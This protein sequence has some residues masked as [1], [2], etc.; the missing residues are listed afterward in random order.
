[1][2]QLDGVLILVFLPL[3]ILFCG[4]WLAAPLKDG[5]AGDRLAFAMLAG[6]VLLLAAVAAVNFQQPLSG[7]WAY[8]C[9]AVALPSLW[10]GN[11]VSLWQDLRTLLRSRP[12]GAAFATATYLALLLWPVLS[13][14]ASLFYDGTSNHDSFFWVA[15]AEHLKQHNYMVLPARSPTQPLL[16]ST[17]AIIGWTPAWGRMGA[18]GLL[19]LTSSILNIAPIK[20]YLYATACL[21][22]AWLAGAWLALKT[23]VT[24]RPGRLVAPALATLQPVF[25]FFYGNSNLPNLVGAIAG[26]ALI[27]A[28]ERALRSRAEGRSESDVYLVLTALSFHG[29]LCAYPE[30]APFVL[31]PA[32]L[33]WLRHGFTA[34]FHIAR[35][36][37]VLSAGAILL[38]VALNYATTARA[39]HGFV[40]S[41]SMARADQNWANLF[42]PLNLAEY[43]AGLIS[44]SVPAARQLGLW[45]G[46]PL[47]GLILGTAWAIAWRARDRLGLLAA[48]SGSGVLLLYTIGTGF[49]Y[50]WQKTVQFSGVF[51]AMLFPAAALHVLGALA[52]ESGR[53]Q[54]WP[55]RL[56][57][58]A[59]PAFMVFAT[60]MNFH[61]TYK[62]SERKVISADWFG[63]R[64]DSRTTLRQKP[65]LIEAGTFPMS[66]FHGMWS[67]YFLSESYIYF[68]ARGEQSGG[69]LRGE[70]A[71]EGRLDI[72]DP[73]AV[74]V[75][76]NWAEGFDS[77]SP[78]LRVGREYALLAR[79][80]RV[81]SME[82]VTP[83]N[84]TPAA[85]AR[86]FSF[87]IEPAVAAQ[88]NFILTPRRGQEG[89]AGDWEIQRRTADGTITT[90][91]VGGGPPWRISVP[92]NGRDSQTL[93]FSHAD[94]GL[95]ETGRPF[96]LS[97]LRME[98]VA[99][100][101][102][103]ASGTLDFVHQRDWQ[104][105]LPEGLDPAPKLDGMLAAHDTAALQVAAVPASSDIALQLVA[106]G[107]YGP[108]APSGPL[109][110]ELWFND[111][112]IFSG[113]FEGPGVLRARI[114]SEHWNARPIATIRLRFPQNP[115]NGPRLLLESLTTRAETSPRP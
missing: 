67:A 81:F 57:L 44:L 88:L 36:P 49:A 74:L 19:A 20:L 42:N 63:L 90:K 79:S 23:F 98:S 40:A 101:F 15:G 89:L 26:A 113:F 38:G 11:L 2:N 86:R 104:D 109:L 30:M 100:P 59:V 64:N 16:A 39:W 7:P 8:A 93:V 102:D 34:G 32:G 108:D 73:S 51:I 37:L 92:M 1:M 50:G 22:F 107:H 84:D 72:P 17:T 76:R 80:N 106:R 54:R 27:I 60:A 33:L 3:A 83:L 4:Y 97:Q 91:R 70:V 10:P 48:V 115:S 78:R 31:M 105:C 95:M 85:T 110:T 68:G 5:T 35:W 24:E 43:A 28:F 55:A 75:G 6:L 99:I 114:F 47:T 62:W 41:F 56:A 111:S 65:V 13:D 45:L 25:A 96:E 46:L 52:G 71:N 87:K 58:V 112:L 9:L 21:Y 53:W 103:P 18:E 66:F 29:L 14:P 69:Y 12:L 77:N 61:E 94:A 82:G